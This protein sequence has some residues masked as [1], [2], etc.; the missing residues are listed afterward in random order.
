MCGI[1]D[2]ACCQHLSCRHESTAS[3]IP[4]VFFCEVLYVLR[5]RGVF[6]SS[7]TGLCRVVCCLFFQRKK[8]FCNKKKQKQITYFA[9]NIIIM[10]KQI[11]IGEF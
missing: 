6:N 1:G 11:I 8:F 2:E 4:A 3:G 5:L 7:S 9:K 10:V